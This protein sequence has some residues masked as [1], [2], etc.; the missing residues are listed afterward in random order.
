MP[1]A[2]SEASPA[3]LLVAGRFRWR[4]LVTLYRLSQFVRDPGLR[5]FSRWWRLSYNPADQ[6]QSQLH[7]C[8]PKATAPAS[9][10]RGPWWGSIAIQVMCFSRPRPADRAGSGV[11]V[12]V[13]SLS[14]QGLHG[15]DGLGTTN[16]YPSSGGRGW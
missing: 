12:I 10:N 7:A 4:Q 5:T 13:V 1:P 15:L 8:L 11:I 16:R 9:E 6:H 14:P 2:V 3:P